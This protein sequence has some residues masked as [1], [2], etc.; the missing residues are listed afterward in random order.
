MADIIIIFGYLLTIVAFL[1]NVII[2]FAQAHRSYQLNHKESFYSLFLSAAVLI[3]SFI[4]VL[5]YVTFDIVMSVIIILCAGILFS[6]FAV[7]NV[8]QYLLEHRKSVSSKGQIDFSRRESLHHELIRKIF[9]IILF[10]GIIGLLVGAYE[11]LV[12]LN[13]QYDFQLIIDNYWGALDGL[14]MHVLRNFDF[15]QGIVFLFFF[16]LTTIFTMNEG[17]RI[18]K[19]FYFPLRKLASFGIREKEKETVASYVYFVIG[20]LFAA[21]F[22]YPVPLFSIIGILCFGD[23]AASLFGRKYGKHKLQFNRTKSWEGSIA[24]LLVCFVVTFLLVGFIWGL[25]ASLVFFIVDAI[26]PVLPL[27]DNIGIPLAVTSAYLLLSLLQIP[28]YSI[29]FTLL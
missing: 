18:G 21:I 11:V 6:L 12:Y 26:T 1:F 28:M 23:S 29:I 16:L 15:G 7:F 24:G 19:W 4:L 25:V 17:A 5:V 2:T 14:N 10:F 8:I 22:L 20:M 3:F 13:T 9:H 27:S